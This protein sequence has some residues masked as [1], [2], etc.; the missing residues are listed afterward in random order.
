MPPSV[1]SELL[2]AEC[3]RPTDCVRF[4]L[5]HAVFESHS[6]HVVGHVLLAYF[7]SNPFDFV[8]VIYFVFC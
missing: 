2:A 7:V 4:G 6:K 5:G 3:D 1:E 8:M